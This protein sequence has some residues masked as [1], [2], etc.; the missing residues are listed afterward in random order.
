MWIHILL[1]QLMTVRSVEVKLIASELARQLCSPP[2]QP[3]ST[4]VHLCTFSSEL[5]FS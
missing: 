1:P 2:A 3:E 5:D 4:T